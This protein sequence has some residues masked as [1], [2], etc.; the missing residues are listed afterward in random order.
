MIGVDCY[1]P[2]WF[3]WN[4][5]SALTSVGSSG[6]LHNHIMC[7][8]YRLFRNARYWF[9]FVY[10][11]YLLWLVVR[12]VVRKVQQAVHVSH[13]DYLQHIFEVCVGRHVY[14]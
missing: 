5:C 3:S 13:A 14:L 1:L 2:I 8:S 6:Q 4:V 7:L 10:V 11:I 9:C 12:F